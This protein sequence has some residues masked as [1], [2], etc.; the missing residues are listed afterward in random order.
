[1]WTTFP[2]TDAFSPQQQ[3][4]PPPPPPNHRLAS[5]LFNTNSNDLDFEYLIDAA[6]SSSKGQAPLGGDFAGLAATFDPGDGSFIPIPE[7]LIPPSLLEW[8]QEPKCL[9]VLVSEEINEDET[10]MMRITTT[11]LPDTGCSVDNLETIK[12][13]DEIDLESQ[14]SCRIEE[15]GEI[16]EEGA[17]TVVGL[18]YP[19][20]DDS[21]ELRVE[22]IFGLEAEDGK[23][24]RMRVAID[25]VPSPPDTFGIQSPMVL[26]LERRTNAVSSGGTIGDGGGLDGRTVSML[27]GERLSGSKTFV[28][29][30]PLSENYDAD[31]IKHVAFPGNVSIAYGWVTD[32]DWVLQVSHVGPNGMRRVV[33]RQFTVSG[34][35]ELDFEIRSWV[36]DPQEVAMT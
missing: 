36:E 4:R 16:Q 34:D 27:L 3:L 14:W 33:S 10:S 7:Y 25:V 24:Y 5:R 13:A 29:D 35:G 18:Q 12:A 11:V 32:N 31:S 8:G 26:T 21:N 6:T 20:Q 23:Q 28:D 19:L 30:P 17:T 9:E 1:M 15:Q 22:T 2:A